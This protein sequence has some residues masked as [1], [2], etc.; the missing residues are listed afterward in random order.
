MR[1][2]AIVG[3]GSPLLGVVLNLIL[4]GAAASVSF[5][6]D[7]GSFRTVFRD[8]FDGAE[9]DE[10]KWNIEVAPAPVQRSHLVA[11]EH[12]RQRA[13]VRADC[14]GQGCRNVASV[15]ASGCWSQACE[16]NGMWCRAHARDSSSSDQTAMMEAPP[17]PVARQASITQKMF[18]VK[19]QSPAITARTVRPQFPDELVHHELRP[20]YLPHILNVSTSADARRQRRTDSRTERTSSSQLARVE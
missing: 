19:R 16:G 2:S 10:R 12:I 1:F 18:V 20:C 11:G 17:M 3:A 6:D 4:P 5:C 13:K 7:D 14:S 9:L 8:D 15:C